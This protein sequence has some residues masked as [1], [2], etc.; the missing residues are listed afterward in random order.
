MARSIG[1][2][3]EGLE[4]PRARRGKRHLLSDMMV[5][6]LCAVICGAEDWVGVSTFGRAKRKWFKTWLHLPYGIPSHFTFERVFA[7]LRPD[8]L[9]GC[10]AEWMRAL[11]ERKENL[12]AIDGKT[13]R[14]SFDRADGQAAIHMVSA[15]ASANELVFAQLACEAKS[16]EI[17]AIPKLLDLLDL[18]G[19]T[20]TID[21]QG[22]QKEIAA[23][24]VAGG[25][26]YVLALKANQPT[27]H[28]EVKLFLDE[29]IGKDF[30]GIAHV[31]EESTEKDHGRIE[32]RRCWV[33]P[34]VAW[35]ED[36]EQWA[37]LRSFAA[38]ECER[39]VGDNTSCERRYFISSLPG[40][41]AEAMA[42]A[43]RSHWGIENKLHWVLDVGFHEDDSR[44]R[45]GHGAENFSRLR[46]MALNLLRRNK[47]EKMGIANKR[48]LAG[49]DHD[50]LLKLLTS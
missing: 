3:F 9:E 2:P 49:W 44:L 31:S 28:E 12:V 22:C 34:E 16:N 17:T 37:G 45:K 39:T 21:A 1:E 15:W 30:K 33:T 25:G 7:A 32:T 11:A 41:D 4:D 47:T 46:R 42:R 18:Q 36:R 35:F 23:K 29:A 6:A 26:D 48:L 13:L 10:F 27:M 14:H 43:V 50:Y 20:V 24:I 19:V 8:A 38:V 40:T 5:I